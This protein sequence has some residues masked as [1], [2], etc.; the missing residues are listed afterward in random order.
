MNKCWKRFLCATL[1]VFQLI[2]VSGI[3][4]AESKAEAPQLLETLED[5][6]SFSQPCS[7]PGTIETVTYDSRAYA[8]EAVNHADQIIIEKTMYVYLPFGYD[9]S[10]QYNVLYLLHG[11]MEEAGYW[12]GLGEKY[13]NQE[14]YAPTGNIT[15][16]LLD[17]LIA[18]GQ[19]EP[20]IVVTPSFYSYADGYSGSMTGEEFPDWFWLELK[21]DIMPYVQNHYATFASKGSMEDLTAARDHQA[22]CG[23]SQGGITAYHSVL[24]HCTDVFSWVGIFS[25]GDIRYKIEMKDGKF[26]GLV[27]E[28]DET[29]LEEACA[30][31]NASVDSQP[32]R[33]LYHACGDQDP[34]MFNY[35]K[36]TYGRMLNLCPEALTEGRNTLFHVNHGYTHNYQS[37]ILDLYNVLQIFFK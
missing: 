1:A 24:S 23:L 29:H 5:A 8:L 32:I 28:I 21:N 3:A 12:F 31:I 35:H 33:F 14:S 17:H 27:T 9:A 19:I 22:Y 18:E 26:T 6:A 34:I 10:K 2:A 16:N 4:F 15:Q 20:L 37:W 13:A 11:G 7:Q 25:A 30:N 36:D